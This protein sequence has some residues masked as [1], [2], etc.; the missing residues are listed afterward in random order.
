MRPYLYGE[1]AIARQS[2]IG[3]V[4]VCAGVEIVLGNSTSKEVRKGFLS[5]K[6]RGINSDMNYV[7]SLWKHRKELVWFPIGVRLSCLN[8]TVGKKIIES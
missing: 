4:A 1:N 3:A 5:H 6:W 7:F 2:S 8:V